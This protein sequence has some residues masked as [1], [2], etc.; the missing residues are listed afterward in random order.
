MSF[1]FFWFFRK[2]KEPPSPQ[3]K[4]EEKTADKDIFFLE[5]KACL[6][7]LHATNPR[8]DKQRIEQAKGGL[9]HDC[10]KWILANDDFQRWQ[11]GQNQ[12]LWIRGDPGK[13]KTMLLCG[14][15]NELKRLPATNTSYFFCQATNARI[16]T[17]TAV[18]RGLIYLL[19]DRRPSLIS[20]IRDKYDRAGKQLFEDANSWIALSDIFTNT[21]QDLGL[22]TTY[23]VID[24]LDECIMGLSDLMRLVLQTS[25][26]NSRVKWVVSSRNWPDIEKAF[27]KA[28]NF[29][30]SLELNEKSV[31]TAVATYIKFKVETLAKDN[32]YDLD[33]HDI[34]Q[35][36][37]THNAGGTFLW[38]ALV[39]QE[40][41]ELSAWAVDEERLAMFPPG[42]EALY[43]RMMDQID[44]SRHPQLCKSILAT[45]SVIYRPITLDELP[46]LVDIPL[47]AVGKDKALSEIIG[48][49]GSF[50]SL[51]DRTVF[52]THQSAKDFLTKEESQT[53]F[54][55][56]EEIEHQAILAR[57]IKAMSQ[58]LHKDIYSLLHPGISIEEVKGKCPNPNPLAPIQYACVHWIEHFREAQNASDNVIIS[59]FLR[60]HF[61]HWFEALSILESTSQG[62][63]ALSKILSLLE[64]S[65]HVLQKRSHIL[66]GQE[67]GTKVPT[68]C[69]GS[70]HASICS[71]LQG[72]N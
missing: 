24:A 4:R 71:F 69:P 18:L 46:S 1:V 23:L 5:N 3:K 32:D 55:D 41:A 62:V 50:L 59:T 58:I 48:T 6:K 53:I 40:L 7:H 17:A 33:A 22:G 8:D 70:R 68:C 64:V 45:L 21:L 25:T 30:V 35:S 44:I 10:Y 28:Q 61:L 52:F 2:K 20:H 27:S 31:S 39:C 26:T 42:L 66:I 54:P 49:C 67:I 14:V 72:H 19:I 38:V 57:S 15:I 12:L 51:R 37:L 9:L 65:S 34:V 13:G 29:G 16:N 11:N 63:L 60:K 47:R 43:K 36:Y 56:G